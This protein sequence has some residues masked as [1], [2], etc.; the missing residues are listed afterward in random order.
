MS[1]EII[2]QLKR[3]IEN[4]KNAIENL[5][6]QLDASK[7]MFNDAINHNLHFRTQINIFQK[8]T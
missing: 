4:Y 3:E 7:Q 5:T 2:N 1:D 6:A 8:T